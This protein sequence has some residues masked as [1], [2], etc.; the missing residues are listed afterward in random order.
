MAG[1]SELDAVC[2]FQLFDPVVLDRDAVVLGQLVVLGRRPVVSEDRRELLEIAFQ[3]AGR[4]NLDDRGRPAGRVPHGVRRAARLDQ[5]AALLCR[6]HPVPIRTPTAPDSTSENSSSRSW[7]C[8]FTSV[9][10]G[11]ST[12]ITASAPP[13][14]ALTTL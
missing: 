3:P 13:E 9:P 12:S 8:G 7:L 10:A 1:R 2:L 4:D 11:I 6:Q 14:S 5:P